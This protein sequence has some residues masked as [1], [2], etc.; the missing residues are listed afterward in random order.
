MGIKMPSPHAN[1]GKYKRKP[2][3]NEGIGNQL[4]EKTQSFALSTVIWYTKL[5]SLVCIPTM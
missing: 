2:N 4:G 5:N 3:Q 1:E